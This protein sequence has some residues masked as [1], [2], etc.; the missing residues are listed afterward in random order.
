MIFFL[1]VLIFISKISL[2]FLP[3]MP[4]ELGPIIF[5]SG[6]HPYVNIALN[7]IFGGLFCLHWLWKANPLYSQARFYRF[8][9]FVT[10]IYLLSIT[11]LQALFVNGDNSLVLQ[12]ASA[13][14]AVFT[15]FLYGRVIPTSL[16]PQKFVE[17]VKKITVACCWISLVLLII[18]PDTSFKGS[19]FIGV[20]KHIPHMV[21]C[22]TIAC[23]TL[24]YFIFSK[25]LKR[26]H[27]ILQWLHFLVALFLLILTGTRSS[28]AAVFLGM[29][30]CMIFFGA[31]TAGNRMLKSSIAISGLLIVI[32]FGINI[33][34]YAVGLARGEE[35]I[36]Q[37][38]AQDGLESRWQEVERGFEIFQK[39]QWLGQ[40]LL[41][42]FSTANDADIAGYN[43]NKDPHNIIISA[44][45]LGGWG[46]IF[47]CVYGFSALGVASFKTLFSKSDAL[48]IIS[49]YVLTH[50][51]ILFIYHIHLSIGGIADRI[52]WIA[53]GY[54]ALKESDVLAD[55]QK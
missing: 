41:S 24:F 18:S 1:L 38:A 55:D 6:L 13:I 47:L 10:S 14:M 4:R 31:K 7:M 27:H 2:A 28:L 54:M 42:K 44:G 9:I 52:Y 15:I 45:V 23:F 46:L 32:F 53:F 26:T 17:I 11:L 5:Q 19:R 25:K 49:I 30:L 16:T 39:N 34:N 51:P 40:G 29:F 8:F 3:G 12:M 21:S 22:A 20:F 37:R 33:S 48:K 35:S 50:L 36:G 43:A